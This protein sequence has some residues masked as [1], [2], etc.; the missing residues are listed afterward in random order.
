[1]FFWFFFPPEESDYILS[2]T[3]GGTP[4]WESRTSEAGAIDRFTLTVPG[5][6][7]GLYAWKTT[8]TGQ[9]WRHG[10]DDA[11]AAAF[12]TPRHGHHYHSSDEC[13]RALGAARRGVAS[14]YK[15]NTT[16][17]KKKKK[18]YDD[19]SKTIMSTSIVS[20]CVRYH[21]KKKN[22]RKAGKTSSYGGKWNPE[23]DV[24]FRTRVRKGNS[25]A[26]ERTEFPAVFGGTMVPA[27][28]WTR[29][30]GKVDDRLFFV[31]RPWPMLI[32][33]RAC[34]RAHGPYRIPV[35]RFLAGFLSYFSSSSS[36]SVLHPDL[37]HGRT[38]SEHF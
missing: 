9:G 3:A 34:V 22:S 5:R 11:A 16:N 19:G 36:S 7:T 27:A 14:V 24:S 21:R 35:N 6:G 10:I 17:R 13:A 31:V 26:I 37:L 2:W 20:A 30:C 23:V 18:I 4:P 33:V 38:A 15:N 12:V 25:V 32:E 29:V 1:M 8:T 28:Q